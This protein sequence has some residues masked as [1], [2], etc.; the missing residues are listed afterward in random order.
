MK[1]ANFNAHSSYSGAG[2]CCRK[3]LMEE[4]RFFDCSRRSREPAVGLVARRGIG[5]MA[6]R[7]IKFDEAVARVLAVALLGAMA[8]RR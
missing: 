4:R 2:L 3:P 7:R 6:A 5:A 8:L 1:T